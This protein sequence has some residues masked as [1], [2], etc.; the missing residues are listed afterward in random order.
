MKISIPKPCSENWNQMTPSE[1]GRFCTSCQT[2][3]INFKG[4]SVEEIKYFLEQQTGSSCGRFSRYQIENFNATYQELPSPSN[5]RK[6]T[7]AAV[8]A[9]VSA[10]PTFAQDNSSTPTVP[11]LN[12]SISYYHYKLQ[13]TEVTTAVPT[14]DTIVLAG[15]VIDTQIN[16]GLPFANVIIPGTKIGTTTDFDGK[17]FLKIPKSKQE[18]TLEVHYIGYHNT[19]FSVVP[20]SNKTDLVFNVEGNASIMGNM[21]GG[22][23]V[24]SKKETKAYK[25][26]QKKELRAERKRERAKRRAEKH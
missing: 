3:V 14:G 9:G 18:I 16:E 21:L 22:I 5:L 23:M 17:F 24:I 6:W 15:K 26:T 4:K 1:K 25:R 7:M 13:K 2:Q 8:L 12:T 10:L 20:D 11:L 19:S